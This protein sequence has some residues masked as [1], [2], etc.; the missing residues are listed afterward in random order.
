[1]VSFHQRWNIMAS[2]LLDAWQN[3]KEKKTFYFS[4]T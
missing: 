3:S 4:Q 2:L 1:L